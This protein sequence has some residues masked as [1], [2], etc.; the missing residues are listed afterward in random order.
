MKRFLLFGLMGLLLVACSKDEV[1]D[2]NNI[3]AF[4]AANWQTFEGVWSIDGT[5]V[6]QTYTI[7]YNLKNTGKEVY[8][9]DFPYQAVVECMLTKINGVTTA[10]IKT[11]DHGFTMSASLVGQSEENNYYNASSAQGLFYEKSSNVK[12][13]PLSFEVKTQDNGTIIYTLGLDYNE[14]IFSVS[15]TATSCVLVV[16]R[17]EITNED[18]SQKTLMLNPARKMTFVS[19]K[20]IE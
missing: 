8:F 4:N 2:I 6:E 15:N 10:D 1:D 3:A 7:T 12:E 18:G 11:P 20:K 16:Q 9:K 5:P 17:V 13:R 14:S 19:T